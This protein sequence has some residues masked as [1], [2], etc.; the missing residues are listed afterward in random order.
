MKKTLI[1]IFALLALT[2]TLSAENAVFGYL[3]IIGKVKEQVQSEGSDVAGLI[4]T[5]DGGQLKFHTFYKKGFFKKRYVWVGVFCGPQENVAQLVSN[6][7]WDG[8]I[9]G[10]L[11][12]YAD[13]ES[14]VMVYHPPVG[15][16]P[17][18][19]PPTTENQWSKIHLDYDNVAQG[20]DFFTQAN[21]GTMWHLLREKYY[22]EYRK[23]EAG[24]N[25]RVS[26]HVY[27]GDRSDK[28]FIVSLYL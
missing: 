14:E 20:V 28:G 5:W 11:K 24:T 16:P 26:L 13:Y 1:L 23:H 17:Q 3:R 4:K 8:D 25:K 9:I 7:A 12:I 22:W 10:R 18:P 19:Q 27:D 15:N 6:G 21:W 2:F